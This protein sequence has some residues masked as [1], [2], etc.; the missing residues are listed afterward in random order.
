[1]RCCP[2]F[3]RV[4]GESCR[5]SVTTTAVCHPDREADDRP[6]GFPHERTGKWACPAAPRRATLS[7][8]RPLTG[9]SRP[10]RDIAVVRKETFGIE[11]ADLRTHHSPGHLSAKEPI[12]LKAWYRRAITRHRMFKALIN[13]R[14]GVVILGD[15]AF[16]RVTTEALE[17]LR[18]K[19]PDVYSLL[20]KHVGCIV[21][22]K[23][24]RFSK[25]VFAACCI[26]SFLALVPTTAVLMRPYGS[27]LSIE[28][29]AGVLA[30]ETYHAELY[31]RAQNGNPRQA[32]PKNA[33]SGE[34]AESL[35]VAY[36]CDVLR[37]LG[38]DEW[39][40]QQWERSLKSKWWEAQGDGWDI[41]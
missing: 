24:T 30:H 12:M 6:G 18:N 34:H 15:D 40:I 19:T 1:L 32:A 22:S 38:V 27:E 3:P 21:S 2:P 25:Q 13:P 4:R 11:K 37:R 31:R 20:Q 28:N 7:G 36:Q 5:E 9:R 26:T 17:L 16:V 35:C 41:L 8:H 29:R 39:D 33:Y 14:G 23:P 10:C